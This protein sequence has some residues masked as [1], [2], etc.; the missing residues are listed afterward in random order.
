HELRARVKTLLEMKRS[1][2]EAVRTEMAFLQAQIKPHF[3]FN[4]LNTIIAIAMSKPQMAHDMLMELSKYLRNSFDFGNRNK[5]T[6]LFKELEL[7]E[8][9]LFIEKTRFGDRLRVVYDLEEGLEGEL[10]PLTIQPLVEN[11]V[12]HGVTKRWSGGTVTIVVRSTEQEIV[13]RVHDDGVGIPKEKLAR[14]FETGEEPGGVGLRN[15]HQRMLRMYGHGLEIES[16]TDH[17]TT[18]SVR[19]PRIERANPADRIGEG[20]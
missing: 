19:I 8:A 14:I 1:A 18:V 2:E 7:V 17:G 9:Y 4:T 13:I 16:E 11:A 12:R 3:L 10:P 5:N 15:I 6:S 20:V